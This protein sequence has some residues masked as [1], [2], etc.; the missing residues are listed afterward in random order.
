MNLREA[1]LPILE[2]VDK[3]VKKN[4][5]LGDFQNVANAT[6]QLITDAFVKALRLKAM[7]D[8]FE[9][10]PIQQHALYDNNM[11]AINLLAKAR[12]ITYQNC[13]SLKRYR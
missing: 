9:E 4:Y 2:K 5:S 11:K 12:N 7:W 8:T 1:L 10:I 3:S 13:M 6:D